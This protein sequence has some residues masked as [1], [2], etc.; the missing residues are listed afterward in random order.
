VS[1]PSLRIYDTLEESARA[2]GTY[3]LQELEETLK[4]QPHATIAISGG[5]TP[6]PLF[7][8]LANADFNWPRI[9]FFWVDE[10]CVPPSDDQSNFKMANE[11]LLAPAR[12]PQSNVHRICGELS[13]EEAASQYVEEIRFFFSI[14]EGQLPAFDLIHRGM[15]PDAHTA[16]L[17]PG[18]P[19]IRDHTHI[20]AHVWVEKLNMHRVTLL[21]G[22]LSAA[23]QTVL[24]V[25]GGD[26]ADAVRNVLVG[27]EDPLSYPCQI[28]SRDSKATWFLDEDAASKS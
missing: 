24:Q 6:K 17:F 8:F 18:E 23:K 26:K 13:P 21:P 7:A 20:A 12:I 2:C 25:A 1:S 11:V 19:L 4:T 5:S 15:G 10:R 28:A 14:K 16:S 9:H 27:P 3:V 22:V